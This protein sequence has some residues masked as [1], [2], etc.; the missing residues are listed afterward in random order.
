MEQEHKYSYNLNGKTYFI[1]L[2]EQEK[3]KFE[4]MYEVCLFLWGE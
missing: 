2:T 3:I 1:V 4:L